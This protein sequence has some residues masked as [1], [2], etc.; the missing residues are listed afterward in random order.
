MPNLA[1][2]GLAFGD[3]GKGRTVDYLCSSVRRRCLV[4][5]FSGGH[6]AGHTVFTNGIRH[7]HSHFGSGTLRGVPTVWGSPCT[8]YP[9]GFLKELD[10][11]L[12][13]EV[14]PEI[15][16]KEDCPVTTPY[17]IAYNREIEKVNKHGSCGVGFGTTL[18]REENFYSL[19]F[20]DLYHKSVL[21]IKLQIIEDYY[22][23]LGITVHKNI[24]DIF[25]SHC[26]IMTKLDKVFLNENSSNLIDTHILEGSQGLLLDP[27]IGFFPY[28]TRGS[29]SVFDYSSPSEI[30]YVT[31]AYQ[32]RHGNGPMTNE[33]IPHKIEL[34]K[35]ENNI[36]NKY[37]GNFRRTL[38]DLDLLNYSFQK[39]KETYSTNTLVITCLDHIQTDKYRYTSN[40]KIIQCSNRDDFV[41]QIYRGFKGKNKFRRLIISDNAET[42]NM[43]VE[44][45]EV[46]ETRRERPV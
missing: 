34:D 17:D 20:K 26:R 25:I 33:D 45:D 7:I 46:N 10:I 43:R 41:E 16:I 40:G 23:S 30:Y 18:A 13:K 32:T 11:L 2:I 5:R 44:I 6:Q 15:T 22:K 39:Q 24:K 14:S 42:E 38:L 19:K 35:H 8:V 37:Q 36:T 4:H 12:K 29:L 27:E 28:V 9:S 21:E 1:V 3:E 31:R